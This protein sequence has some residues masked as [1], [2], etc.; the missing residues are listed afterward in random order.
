MNMK[1]LVLFVIAGWLSS[2]S[3][4]FINHEL[5]FEKA[6]ECGSEITP[7]NVTSNVSGERYEF[8][9]CLDADF[10]GKNY[11]VERAGD[12]L[13]VSFPK[14]SATKSSFK[15]TLDIDA[16]PLYRH[17]LLDGREVLVGRSE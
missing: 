11:K 1:Y 4:A 9:D 13:I 16:K 5:K 2:C 15:L 14:S 17:I 6:G 8:T 10:D 12:S 3:D 7:I